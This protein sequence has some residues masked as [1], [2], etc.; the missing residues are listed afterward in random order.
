VLTKVLQIVNAACR[1]LWS[2]MRISTFSMKNSLSTFEKF[3]FLK[4]FQ[5]FHPGQFCRNISPWKMNHPLENFPITSRD[6]GIL[7]PGIYPANSTEILAEHHNRW[8]ACYGPQCRLDFGSIPMSGIG[9]FCH[10]PPLNNIRVMVIVWR[11]RRN[12]IRTVLCWV[13]WHNVHNQQHTYIYE[14]F[15]QVQQIGF[16]TLGSLCCA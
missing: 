8:D 4:T 2:C 15:L 6:I 9:C 10:S 5:A 12:I 1:D 7:P 14:Q 11:L 13:V 3:P 16:V